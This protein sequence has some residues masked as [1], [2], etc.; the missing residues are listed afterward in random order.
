MQMFRDCLAAGILAIAPIAAISAPIGFTDASAFQTALGALPYASSTLT[1]ENQSEFDTVDSGSDLEGITFI[2]DFGGILLEINAETDTTSP[3]NYLGTVD[4]GLLQDGDNFDLSFAASNAIGLF[5]T[6][7]P[8]PLVDDDIILTAGGISVGLESLNPLQT[9]P[10]GG[11]E[12][13]LG[14]VDSMTTFD[15][16]S[17]ETVGL[18]AF[19][20][21][22][23]DITLSSGQVVSVTSPAPLVPVM[24]LL[25]VLV[26]VRRT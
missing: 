23:D 21:T 22:V 10:D 13:F 18:G 12:Y 7:A 16:A 25:Y 26:R 1:F 20:Y 17:I 5:I 3:A 8:D 14:I 6:F 4:G 15:S 24:A 9:F 11:V 19:V 2:Y